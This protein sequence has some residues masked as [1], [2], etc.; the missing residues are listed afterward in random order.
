MADKITP[1]WIDYDNDGGR[2]RSDMIYELRCQVCSL[3]EEN[4]ALKKINAELT[5]AVNAKDDVE[6]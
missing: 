3:R 2:M 4:E 1:R 5:R 6:F